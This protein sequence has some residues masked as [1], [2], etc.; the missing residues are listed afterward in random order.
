MEF[1]KDPETPSFNKLVIYVKGDDESFDK[2]WDELKR[3]NKEIRNLSLY[4]DSLKN[5]LS[6]DLW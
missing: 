4:D 2:D 6:V 1:D 3:I 5:L